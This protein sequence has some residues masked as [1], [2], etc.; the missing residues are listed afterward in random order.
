MN[1]KIAVLGC[2]AWATTIANQVCKNGYDVKLWAYK[3]DIVDEMN[4]KRIRKKIP[5]VVLEPNLK[6]FLSIE[7]VLTDVNAI[8][9]CVPSKFLSTTLE[10]WKPFYNKNIPILSLIKGIVSENNMLLTD[11]LDNYFQDPKISVLSGPNL[12]SEISLGKPAASVVAS[13]DNTMGEAN[14]VHIE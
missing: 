5:N 8:I 2:G 6:V 4:I 10:L 12:A 7:E 9:L 3:Q 13:K 1:S 11:Y 14:M